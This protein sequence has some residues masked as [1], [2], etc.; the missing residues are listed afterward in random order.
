MKIVTVCIVLITL[1]VACSEPSA[2]EVPTD[3]GPAANPTPPP[4]ESTQAPVPP[5][6]M[7]ILTPTLEP[8][9]TPTPVPPT[10]TPE[11][12]ATPTPV[13]PTPT[14]TST[15]EPTATP[16]PVPPVTMTLACD[17]SRFVDEIK[18]LSERSDGL[19]KIQILKIY[20]GSEEIERTE[21]VLKC[22]GEAKLSTAVDAFVTYHLTIDRD[23][24]QFIGYQ[25][26]ETTTPPTATPSPEP[27]GTPTPTPPPAL[28]SRENPVPIGNSAV[29][30]FDAQKKWE[31]TVLGTQ[32]DATKA[33]LDEN[34]FNDS[35]IE[36]NQFYIAGVRAKNLAS[37]STMLM[38]SLQFKAAGVE[39]VV[40][41]E[42]DHSC[43]VI[44]GEVKAHTE[45]L[46]NGTIEGAVCWS[47][48]SS[49]TDSLLMI[50]DELFSLSA[51]K[52]FWFALK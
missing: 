12:T 25:I 21:N 11:P 17:D 41:S 37:A 6:T 4:S 3:S 18:K 31:I 46:T 36:G 9:A 27:T 19:F 45:L 13:P 48:K 43:G 52:R 42:F 22:R 15:P 40:Y 2:T 14:A 1:A 26:G 24:D 30:E 5:T 7:P 47:I 49:D 50:V 16:T 8:T 34:Q 23:G 20:E 29:V 28:G 51:S 38:R 39:G 44:P 32:P 33:V 10:P 35:P